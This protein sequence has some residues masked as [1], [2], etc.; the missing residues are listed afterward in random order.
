MGKNLKLQDL[1]LE[2]LMGK[3]LK[4]QDLHLVILIN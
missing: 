3:N 4:L 2:I 1:H